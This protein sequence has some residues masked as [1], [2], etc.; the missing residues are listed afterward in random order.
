LGFCSLRE[1]SGVA[2]GVEE[3]RAAPIGVAPRGDLLGEVGDPALD[4]AAE[5]EADELAHGHDEPHRADPALAVEVGVAAQVLL[6]R[7]EPAEQHDQR[8][9]P[10]STAASERR[11]GGVAR[12]RVPLDER[13]G[14]GRQEVEWHGARRRGAGGGGE[15]GGGGAGEAGP[16]AKW[17][18]MARR[19]GERG[20]HR[21]PDLDA[22]ERDA[23]VRSGG[24]EGRGEVAGGGRSHGRMPEA[25]WVEPKRR[26]RSGEG[27]EELKR[28]EA[29]H[30]APGGLY[31]GDG[32]GWVTDAWAHS[33]QA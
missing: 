2:E 7:A 4:A 25:D 6:A 13:V 21:G 28:D 8:G 23:L 16:A 22:P 12:G 33:T 10:G 9:A 24:R 17:R 29:R 1:P 20:G 14:V 30:P 15:R 18:G 26:R 11:G 31:D 3:E 32:K 19:E 5:V 27:D